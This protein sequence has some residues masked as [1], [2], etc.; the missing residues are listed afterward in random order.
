MCVCVCVCGVC[1]C[2]FAHNEE[3]LND[4]EEYLETSIVGYHTS[5][6]SLIGRECVV[7]E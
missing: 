5:P 7:C 2:A 3:K 6:F 1:V 4:N